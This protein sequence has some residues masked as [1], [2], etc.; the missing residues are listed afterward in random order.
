MDASETDNKSMNRFYKQ[1]WSE[2]DKTINFF[3][4]ESL[5]RNSD[6]APFNSDYLWT[7][8]KLLVV[9]EKGEVL[10]SA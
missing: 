3:I 1:F 7:R 9:N 5:M 6:L 2:I 10:G 4:N 8:L